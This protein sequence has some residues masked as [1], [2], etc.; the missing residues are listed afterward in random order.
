[1]WFEGKKGYMMKSIQGRLPINDIELVENID[2]LFENEVI[3]Y[4][5]G[6]CGKKA[7]KNL[8]MAGLAI[9]HFCDGDSSKWEQDINGIKVISPDELKS[10]DKKKNL[11]IIIASYNVHI[12]EQIISNIA[13][14]ELKTNKIYTE[15]SLKFSL[16]KNSKSYR[17]SETYRDVCKLYFSAVESK[18]SLVH[19]NNIVRYLDNIYTDI[20]IY[21]PGKVGSSTVY[22]SLTEIGIAC[23]QLHT[24]NFWNNKEFNTYSDLFKKTDMLKIIT[25]VREPI[26]RDISMIFESLNYIAH[27][28][29]ENSFLNL[30]IEFLK[31]A[32]SISSLFI[33]AKQFDWFDNELK[34]IFGID[35]YAHPFNRENGYCIIK[36]DNIEVLAIK[37]EKLSSLEAVIGK[38][39]GI[40]DFK[41]INDRMSDNRWY[42]YLYKNVK[43]TIKIPREIFDMYYK[44]NPKM[45]HF[46]TEEEKAAF[47]KKWENNI[48]N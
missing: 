41:L 47:L 24:L 11:V 10:L 7:C 31:R 8:K 48:A 6:I 1:M 20:L 40:L 4:G 39:A 45:D 18:H 28:S 33:D 25:L 14:L 26:S 30:C 34:I 13:D 29:H 22:K 16:I 2:I 9:L 3:L 12:T 46:Y 36:Q 23:T 21:Q 15:F 35:I 19:V 43:D 38:F 37:S 17:I 32:K 5:A 44:N 42:K 27:L